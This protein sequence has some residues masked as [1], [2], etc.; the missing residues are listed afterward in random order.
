MKK[1]DTPDS[2]KTGCDICAEFAGFPTDLK[3]DM[4][5]DTPPTIENYKCQDPEEADCNGRT[6]NNTAFMYAL[7]TVLR[8]A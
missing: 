1:L 4:C 6:Y 8:V 3:G 5:A 2:V 7:F